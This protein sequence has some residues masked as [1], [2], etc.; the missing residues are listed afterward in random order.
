MNPKEKRTPETLNIIDDKLLMKGLHCLP[1]VRV[2]RKCVH[3]WDGVSRDLHTTSA[4]GK[5]AAQMLLL[6]H[7]EDPFDAEGKCRAKKLAR[8]LQLLSTTFAAGSSA[9]GMAASFKRK[10]SSHGGNGAVLE[11]HGCDAAAL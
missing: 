7:D 1:L 4:S 11:I 3:C 5:R 10:N 6:L 2:S 9:I 8:Q